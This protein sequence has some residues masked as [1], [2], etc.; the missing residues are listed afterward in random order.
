MVF[1]SGFVPC[2]AERKEVFYDV[3]EY[4]AGRLKILAVAV[5]PGSIGVGK[6]KSIVKGD[7]VLT[8]TAPLFAVPGDE[9][10]ASVTV[11]N[12]LEGDAITDQINVTAEADGGV[13]II[14]AAPEGQTI[15]VGKEVTVQFLCRA[16]EQLGNCLLYT[17]PSPRDLSTSRM[18][19]SA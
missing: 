17:S 19:S 10:T 15:A 16:T 8:S 5:A 7:F 4:F 1:W 6:A 2:D 11:A 9:F 3:P 14:K 12:Q 18:P 13:E